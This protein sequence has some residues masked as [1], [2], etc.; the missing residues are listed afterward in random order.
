MNTGIRYF[1]DSEAVKV[2]TLGSSGTWSQR[3]NK[4]Q[5]Q[6]TL[7]SR[8]KCYQLRFIYLFVYLFFSLRTIF[9]WQIPQPFFSSACVC[10]LSHFS[11]VRLF[12]TPRTV[13]HQAPLSMNSPG[14]NTGV[15][16]KRT[17]ISLA[18]LLVHLDHYCFTHN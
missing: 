12:A 6:I 9:R 15:E 8:G 7:S 4:P 17:I 1:P 18:L 13:A 14:K 2:G 11:H 3:R 16:G 10:V 5:L